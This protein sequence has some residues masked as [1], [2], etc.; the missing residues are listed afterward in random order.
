VNVRAQFTALRLDEV[1]WL[2]NVN[3]DEN[4]AI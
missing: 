2:M 4:L 1:A 3:C